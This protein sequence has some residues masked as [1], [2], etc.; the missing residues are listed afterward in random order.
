M[1]RDE[2]HLIFPGLS[3][4]LRVHNKQ[5]C[6]HHLK[7][8]P[9]L[10]TAVPSL[11]PKDDHPVLIYRAS[12]LVNAANPFCRCDYI[13]GPQWGH[14]TTL[15]SGLSVIARVLGMQKGRGGT[16]LV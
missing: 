3:L 11:Y 6:F 10:L 2:R 9:V 13:Q 14:H 8:V 4:G 15:S 12:E 5:K 1:T 7:E 16:E